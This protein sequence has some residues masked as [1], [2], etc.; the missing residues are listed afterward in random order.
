MEPPRQCSLVA[1]CHLTP[2]SSPC[3]RQRHVLKQPNG[4]MLP[5]VRPWS[6]PCATPP[7]RCG[8]EQLLPISL[9]RWQPSTTG[10]GCLAAWQAS[11]IHVLGWALS[12][13]R[14]PRSPHAGVEFRVT[15]EFDE[16]LPFA[17]KGAVQGPPVQSGTAEA[18]ARATKEASDPLR[19]AST[20]GRGVSSSTS[21][22]GGMIDFT[23]FLCSN[24]YS[25]AVIAVLLCSR[26]SSSCKW[27]AQGG[28]HI[29]P[30]VPP[31]ADSRGLPHVGAPASLQ[32]ISEVGTQLLRACRRR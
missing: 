11:P 14:R 4:A 16:D 20:P 27:L 18:V 12:A 10:R 19:A 15:E 9:G 3:L 1:C 28:V 21:G 5:A 29:G 22:S 6:P 26:Q 32:N 24:V 8:A 30:V 7:S 23:G 31:G 17:A 13:L 2:H 25:V